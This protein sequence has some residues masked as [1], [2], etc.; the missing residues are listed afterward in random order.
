MYRYEQFDREKLAYTMDVFDDYERRFAQAR[1]AHPKRE[2]WK[3]ADR[4][5]IAAAL[6]DVIRFDEAMIPEI[7]VRETEEGVC[8]GFSV[9]H[10]LFESWEGFYGIATLVFPHVGEN[11]GEKRPAVVICP[12]HGDAGRLTPSYQRMA[13]TIAAQGAYA[14]IL[15]NL[16][17]GCR[18]P[19]GHKVVPEAFYCGQTVQGMIVMEACGWINWL[20]EQ[21]FVDEC[22]IAACGNSGGG[23]ETLMLAGVNP[24]L[25]AVAS[26]GFPSEY[27]YVLQKERRHCDCNLMR[28]ICGRL[29]MWEIYSLFAPRPLLVECGCF[30]HLLPVDTFHRNAR[31]CAAVWQMMG[32]GENFRAEI[33]QEKHSW[34]A[35]DIVVIADF[36]ADVLGLVKAEAAPEEGLIAPED[37][38]LPFPADALGTGEG[39]QRLTGMKMPG[40]MTLADI[41]PPMYHGEPVDPEKIIPDLGRGNVMRV[42]AQQEMS[43]WDG[44]KRK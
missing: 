35:A 3:E 17:Q 9:L 19:F 2:P 13:L 5:E 40:G 1:L 36:L 30:D 44:L 4:A 29:E 27:P 43:L 28:G 11:A 31:K 41:F 22:R 6:R 33:T 38:K 39:I 42:L 23:T 32:A 18:S 10:M 8:Q 25:A 15:E 21:P 34:T 20:R 37:V 14:L 26:T 7:H 24:Y 12:G 16:G